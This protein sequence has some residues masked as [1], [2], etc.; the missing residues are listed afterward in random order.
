MMYH[1]AIVISQNCI[2]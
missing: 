2:S 1:V